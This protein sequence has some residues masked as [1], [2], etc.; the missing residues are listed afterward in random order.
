MTAVE[1]EELVVCGALAQLIR[2]HF[3]EPDAVVLEEV[4]L[5]LVGHEVGLLVALEAV[6][7]KED[8]DRVEGLGEVEEAVEG[9]EDAVAG[10]LRVEEADDV[11]VFELVA[12]EGFDGAGVIVCEAQVIGLLVAFGVLLD[13]DQVLVVRDADDERVAAALEPVVRLA[14]S[15]PCLCLQ[16]EILRREGRS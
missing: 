8:E 7:G 6:P 12:E 15:R 4:E 2:E 3:I 1:N 16:A 14:A 10:G 11:V 5:G 13:G 9:F